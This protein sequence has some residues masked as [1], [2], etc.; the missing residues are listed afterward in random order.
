MRKILLIAIFLVFNARLHSLDMNFAGERISINTHS[1][2]EINEIRKKNA[3]SGYFRSQLSGSSNNGK[4]KGPFN[5]RRTFYDENVHYENMLT[6]N[7]NQVFNNSDDKFNASIGLRHSD[8]RNIQ[9]NIVG[10]TN[11]RVDY[12]HKDK[13]N[14]SIGDI[15]VRRSKYIYA[16]RSRGMSID[17]I[18]DALGGTITPVAGFGFYQNSQYGMLEPQYSAFVGAS[19]NRNYEDSFLKATKVNFDYANT[20]FDNKDKTVANKSGSTGAAGLAIKMKMQHSINFSAELAVIANKSDKSKSGDESAFLIEGRKRFDFGSFRAG[21]EEVSPGFISLAALNRN[22]FRKI[23]ADFNTRISQYISG[24]VGI[25]TFQD[26]LDGKKTIEA[27]ATNPFFHCSLRLF[28]TSNYHA[29]IK[30]LRFTSYLNWAFRK[31]SDKS[32]DRVVS[33]QNFSA[34][35]YMDNWNFVLSYRRSQSADDVNPLVNRTGDR[36]LISISNPHFFESIAKN[37]LGINDIKGGFNCSWNWANDM[38]EIQKILNMNNNVIFRIFAE[39][40]GY[41]FNAG[42]NY[43]LNG[44]GKG[45]KS[46]ERT[47][48]NISAKKIFQGLIG[49]KNFSIGIVVRKSLFIN[50]VFSNS[51]SSMNYWFQFGSSF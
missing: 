28:P 18:F 15:Y 12:R 4:T 47:N 27:S 43:F 26:N 50:Q 13:M 44:L 46:F 8:R 32:L 42:I 10:L 16:R 36:I 19:Y 51:F 24:G 45:Q 6:L 48:W 41:S 34:N 20:W 17:Y 25:N 3:I 35:S 31:T 11:I 14:L 33:N 2:L 1:K 7:Y 5:D 9:D 40:K 49:L 23:F 39:T 21:W 30:N 37:L 22:D 29:L 38:I